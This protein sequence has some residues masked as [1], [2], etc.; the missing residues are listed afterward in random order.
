MLR[1]VASTLPQRRQWTAKGVR[2]A[3]QVKGITASPK[4]VYNALGYLRRKGHIKQVSYGH[5]IVKDIGVGIVTS[6]DL[7]AEPRIEDD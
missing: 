6:D 3:I 5:Y 1:V 7:G 4:Q 2:E